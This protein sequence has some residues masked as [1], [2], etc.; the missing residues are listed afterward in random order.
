[1]AGLLWL[2]RARLAEREGDPAAARAAW[3]AALGPLSAAD[4]RPALLHALRAAARL[5]DADPAGA[6]EAAALH[7]RAAGV[8]AGLGRAAVADDEAAE[9]G[10]PGR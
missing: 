2:A 1:M 10:L 9:G 8:A 5:A 7:R 4:D 3:R 6:E